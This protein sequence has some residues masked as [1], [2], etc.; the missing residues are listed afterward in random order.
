M[1]ERTSAATRVLNLS[2]KTTAFRKNNWVFEV[3]P[4][5]RRNAES[6]QDLRDNLRLKKH[7][8]QAVGAESAPLSVIQA[9]REGIRK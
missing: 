6:F 3:E 4:Y 8:K 7:L 1:I 5:S 9:I 2:A